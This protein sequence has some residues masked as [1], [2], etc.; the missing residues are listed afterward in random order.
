MNFIKVAGFCVA[1]TALSFSFQSC[2]GEKVDQCKDL[3]SDTQCESCCH[4]NG[5]NGY[6]FNSTK[7]EP[8]ECM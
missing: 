1:F 8:C 5:F 6:K 2:K 3:S 4:S 7:S